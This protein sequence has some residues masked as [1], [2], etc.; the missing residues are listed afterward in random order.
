MP[1][2]PFFLARVQIM[3]TLL[4]KHIVELLREGDE[5]AIS[6]LYEH[7]GDTL[8]GVARRYGVT[9]PELAAANG[10][11]NQSHL[12]VGAR[13]E[14]P[15]KSNGGLSISS[16]NARMTYQVRRGD[17]LSE[18]ADR[19]NVSVN[20]L[21]SWNQLRRSTSL[22]AGQKLVVYADPRKVNGG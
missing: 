22:K 7:Y 11:G 15:G 9:I 8:Y 20:Q 10:M 12:A 21:K 4:E 17:T 18:I 19:F 14:I 2:S 6:L 16:E 1:T 3:S 5:K 13:L